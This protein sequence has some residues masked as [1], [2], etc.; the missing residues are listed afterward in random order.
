[1]SESHLLQKHVLQLNLPES[2]NT[3]AG[4]MNR[5]A[6]YARLYWAVGSW[7]PEDEVLATWR[8]GRA[9]LL[10]RFIEW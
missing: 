8:D 2:G 1:M 3:D 6:D 9:G 10:V 5:E 4:I 7:R